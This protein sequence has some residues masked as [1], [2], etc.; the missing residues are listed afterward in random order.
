M[1]AQTNKVF[2]FDLH[3]QATRC[4]FRLL[5][6][7]NKR[8]SLCEILRGETDEIGNKRK[9]NITKTVGGKSKGYKQRK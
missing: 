4:V 5:V 3:T 2:V 6:K 9:N 7:L 1:Q 8:F